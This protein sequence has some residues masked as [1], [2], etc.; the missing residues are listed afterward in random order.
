MLET[1][2]VAVGVAIASKIPNPLISIPLVLASHFLL[3]MTPHWNPHINR[4]IKK[5]GAPTKQSVNIIRAD[6]VIALILGSAIAFH[7][8]PNTMQVFN[9]LACSFVSVLPDVV[10][11]PYYFLHKKY[12]IIEKWITW[13]KSIQ[14]DVPPLYGLSVQ[15]LVIV[16]SLVWIFS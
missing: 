8:E 14:N 16:A 6:S 4:E 11:I 3:D 2:H 15:G 1:P 10:E 9:I 12:T 13:Q 5:Y 7:A